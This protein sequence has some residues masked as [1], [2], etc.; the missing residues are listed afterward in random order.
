[1]VNAR[2]VLCCDTVNLAAAMVRI[3]EGAHAHLGKEPGPMAS[4]VA[5]KLG[6]HLRRQIVGLNPVRHG[7]RRQPR[8]QGPVTTDGAPHQPLVGQSIE[9]ALLAIPRRSC[10]HEGEVTGATGL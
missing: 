3:N 2:E 1:V 5:K 6:D 7:Q 8:Y 10:K 4:A 9:T